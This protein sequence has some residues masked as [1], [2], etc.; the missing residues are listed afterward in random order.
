MREGVEPGLAMAR[1]H[2][3]RAHAAK[4][5]PR[6]REMQDDVVDAHAAGTRPFQHGALRVAR[7][8]EAI[9]GQRRGP[10]VDKR[11]RLV[12][13]IHREDRQDRPEDL[14]PHHRVIG[15]DVAQNRGRKIA[16]CAIDLR[17][18]RDRAALQQRD[19]AREMR[20]VDD[21]PVVRARAR[22]LAEAGA[23]G[24]DARADER[25]LDSAVHEHVVRRDAGL[26]CVEE[27]APDD[28]PRG[29]A[30]V[31]RRLDDAGRLAAELE[32]D[33]DEVRRGGGEDFAAD[34]G[35][36]GEEDRV[37]RQ[38]GQRGG[39]VGAAS[40]D[41]HGVGV[42]D[43]RQ[44]RGEPRRAG[45]RELRGLEHDAVAGRQGGH[46]RHQRELDRIVPR[47]EDQRRAVGAGVD[48]AAPR[49]HREGNRHAPRPRP[50]AE[51]RKG[52]GDLL[53][54]EGRLREMRFEAGLAEILRERVSDPA[55]VASQQRVQPLELAPPPVEPERTACAEGPLQAGEHGGRGGGVGHGGKGWKGARRG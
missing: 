27:L 33:R 46:E 1:P 49:P 38:R 44:P 23:H 41:R 50:A 25:R 31:R 43:L 40:R 53:P 39:D 26:P 54:H 4:R 14:L 9:Q 28:P 7:A 55:P 30:D 15:R 29:D 47:R 10:R 22:V 36:A 19:E 45:G 34:G 51:I 37:E 35:A 11:D 48:F 24:L 6:R 3:A 18:G 52:G 32:R 12:Q 21:A 20:L 17:P 42:E 8:A 5:Q 2:A 13:R 16:R